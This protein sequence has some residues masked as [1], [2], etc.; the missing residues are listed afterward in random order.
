MPSNFAF[1]NG[2]PCSIL[3]MFNKGASDAVYRFVED[4]LKSNHPELYDLIDLG[5]QNRHLAKASEGHDDELHLSLHALQLNMNH[6]NFKEVKKLIAG[7]VARCIGVYLDNLQHM[8]MVQFELF[9]DKWLGASFDM[10]TSFGMMKD[11]TPIT[12]MRMCLYGNGEFLPGK[13]TEKLGKIGEYTYYGCYEP[14]TDRIT[15]EDQKRDPKAHAL[16]AV[17]D[18]YWGPGNWKPHVSLY[19]VVE[20][21]TERIMLNSRGHSG[22]SLR[23]IAAHKDPHNPDGI[24]LPDP[25]P[26]GRTVRVLNQ[27]KIRH[28]ESNTTKLMY[29]VK[30]LDAGFGDATGWIY[31]D[32]APTP[33]QY[34]FKKLE[35][36]KKS[37]FKLTNLTLIP[38]CFNA[39]R[40]ATG[41]T[42]K[43]PVNVEILHSN[44]VKTMKQSKGARATQLRDS[45]RHNA[46]MTRIIPDFTKVLVE[47]E[48][49]EPTY[50]SLMYKVK[51]LGGD[52]EGVTGWVYAKNTT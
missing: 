6:P 27:A 49:T 17:H 24:F 8:P 38:D 26:N 45:A 4:D 37:G 23:K 21:T 10:T 13:I 20:D 50:G 44:P 16:Y 47:D 52:L 33:F 42:D 3:L 48:S 40:V 30:C 1:V 51:C 12:T 41:N 31:A 22:T 18:Y 11:K 7:R 32:N 25:I 43:N 9:G 2:I 28:T 19:K 29:E 15:I 34:N 39:Y 46:N 5:F 14:G 36:M 35:K